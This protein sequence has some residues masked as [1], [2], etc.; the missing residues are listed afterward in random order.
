VHDLEVGDGGL[1]R[2]PTSLSRPT[3]AAIT[4]AKEP[5]FLS[6]S[7]ASGF[8]S[9]RGMARNRISSSIS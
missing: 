3:G 2:P 8:T 7:F 9:R 1:A 5:N 4:S 6:S